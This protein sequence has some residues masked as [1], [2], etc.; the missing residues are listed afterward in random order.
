MSKELTTTTNS[1]EKTMTTNKAKNIED[2]YSQSDLQ[3]IKNQYAPDLKEDQFK[4]YLLTCNRLGLD[5]AKRQVYGIMRGNKLSIEISIDGFRYIADSTNCYAPGDSE[6]LYDKQ[7]KIIGAKVWVKKIVQGQVFAFSEIALI[8]E[9]MPDK[10]NFMWKKMP[11]RM[12]AKCAEALALR[13]AFP[14]KL[15]G[16]YCREEMQQADNQTIIPADI[17]KSETIVVNRT[18]NNEEMQQIKELV[19]YDL[20]IIKRIIQRFNVIKFSD[21]MQS[22]FEIIKQY[23]NNLIISPLQLNKLANIIAKS[24]DPEK[25]EKVILSKYKIEKTS[26]L[27]QQQYRELIIVFE[28]K[29]KNGDQHEN[30]QPR[31]ENA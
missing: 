17:E 5:P 28:R 2:I 18:L 6:I 24:S 16:I 9:Y 8:S 25:T 4:V 7:G 12:I 3:A 31:A 23:S 10:N 14:N 29:Q 22:D 13:R 26:E 19:S 1:M 11:H 15:S 20:H 21:L 30:S 27:T